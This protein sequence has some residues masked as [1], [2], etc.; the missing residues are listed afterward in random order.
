MRNFLIQ[1]NMKF[2]TE[3]ERLELPLDVFGDPERR[4][5]PILSQEDVDVAPKRVSVLP[6][7]EEIKTRILNIIAVK[8]FGIPEQWSTASHSEFAEDALRIAALHV[9]NG[10]IAE[11]ELDPDTVKETEDGEYILRTGKIFESG[12]YPDKKFEMTS[13]ELLD[14][15]A[16]FQPVEVDLEHM[17]TILDGKLG[18]LEAVA[19][20]AN[21]K[22]LIGTVRLPKWLDTQL[23]EAE[24][25][26]SATWDRATKKLLKLALV[27]NPRVKDAALMA[28]FMAN[29]LSDSLEGSTQEEAT[30]AIQEVLEEKF[31]KTYHGIGFMQDIHDMCARSGAVC[32][33]SADK[34]AEEQALGF[35]SSSEAGAIQKIHDTALRG[36]AKCHF[37]KE[38][39]GETSPSH[40]KENEMNLKDVTDFLSKMQENVGVAESLSEEAK[41]ELEEKFMEELKTQQ[42][43]EAALRAKI[44]AEVRAELEKE[45]NTEEVVEAPTEEVVEEAVEDEVENSGPSARELELE[46]Q[47]AELKKKDIQ[48]DAELFADAEV[49]AE[50]AFPAE[51]DAL[52]A[53]YTQSA[54]DDISSD[55]EI[56]FSVGSE[57]IT[58]NR[59]EVL[60]AMFASRKPHQM[61]YE[62]IDDTPV[63]VL[64]TYAGD[65]ADYLGDAEKQAREYAAKRRKQ[66]SE[67]K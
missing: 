61:S 8:G 18:K 13:E 51:R 30:K 54:L 53:L 57:E 41:A 60:K 3:K 63:N 27:R 44:E 67:D 6:N 50:R 25:K 2:L 23:G 42:E 29:E 36:G 34:F 40:Y 19:I 17:P 15:I 33:E 14:A 52:V 46:Q 58:G 22:D 9:K 20:G 7:S 56:K 47:L 11:F 48:R 65:E 39:K 66:F 16:D 21:G 43:T 35:V 49:R 37:V 62:Y 45:F 12:S 1:F 31:G 28:A 59:V 26:V 24:R 38:G 64:A 5:L 10:S 4:L 55:A 32:M